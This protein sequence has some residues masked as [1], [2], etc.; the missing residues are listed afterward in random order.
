MEEY[1]FPFNCRRSPHKIDP[2]DNCETYR[3]NYQGDYNIRHQCFA[4]LF[5]DRTH[6]DEHGGAGTAVDQEQSLYRLGMQG[7]RDFPAQ[8]GWLLGHVA[9][10]VPLFT[11][12][13]PAQSSD[14]TMKP[15]QPK[16]P[17]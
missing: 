8:R 16:I 3:E 1:G 10:L 9:S 6:E 11:G 13:T 17:S 12:S 14:F 4:L 5:P 7:S 15:R 2:A